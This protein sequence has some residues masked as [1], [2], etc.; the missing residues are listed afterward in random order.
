MFLGQRKGRKGWS[1]GQHPGED[2]AGWSCP[3]R[4]VL[5]PAGCGNPEHREGPWGGLSGEEPCGK[6]VTDLDDSLDGLVRNG[7]GPGGPMLRQVETC[8]PYPTCDLATWP[9]HRP[10]LRMGHGLWEGWRE[11]RDAAWL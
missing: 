2:W 6:W 7:S 5:V 11:Q 3:D 8:N 9:W 4:A 1:P 10:V